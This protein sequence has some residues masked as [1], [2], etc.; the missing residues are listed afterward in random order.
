MK[1]RIPFGKP[2]IGDEEKQAV[3]EVLDGTIYVH[4]PKAKEFEESFSIFTKAPYAISL[5]SCTAG[6]HLAYLYKGI[7]PGDEVI[8]PAQTH[9]ATAHAVEFVGAKPVFVD[10]EL[11]TGNIDI[12]K[13]ESVVTEKTRA[14]SIV[15]F[16]GMPVDMDRINQIAQK[17]NLF[18]VE[19]CALAVGGRYN[20]IHVGLH[21]DLGCF[22]F[23]PVKHITTAEG[24]MLITKHKNI[25]DKI[26]RR[27]AFGVDRFVGERKIP[28]QYDVNMLGYNYRM[29]EIAAVL[30]I[31]QLKRVE[32]FLGQR[33]INYEML[34]HGLKEIEE[35]H[36][37]KTTHDN[38][39]SSYYCMSVMLN[40]GIASSRDDIINTLNEKGIGTSIYYP[41]PVPYLTYYNEKY[42]YQDNEFPNASC[43]SYQSIAL[44]VGPHLNVN[45]INYIVES[46][47][48][49]IVEAK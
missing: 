15:H 45:D 37:F 24:G 2:I 30:G 38:Y 16:L 34:E 13:I 35:I 23:Y 17:H 10:A 21:G 12:S 3:I 44:P 1:K 9:T 48:E 6:L 4:G 31:E 5:A 46:I 28:G 11:K 27:K 42:G 7:G 20:G 22:S 41:K 8:V 47:K 43:I 25:C 29:N 40:D 49:A 33:K 18:V 36:L 19:D 39:Q 26:E 32:G 14:I